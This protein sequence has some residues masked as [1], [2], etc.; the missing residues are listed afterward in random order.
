MR[1][2]GYFLITAG[3]LVGAYFAVRTPEGLELGPFLLGL[4]IGAVGIVL[5][6]WDLRKAATH[7]GRLTSDLSTLEASLER[8]VENVRVLDRDKASI[9]V[10]DLRHRIDE[11]FPGD[12]AR[13]VE[14][15]QSLAHRYGLQAYADVMN[16]FSAG[17]RYLNR[18]WST[19]TDGYIDEAHE[20]L[21][22]SHEQ[23]EDALAVV[24]R[25]RSEDG[26][27]MDGR[28]PREPGEPADS[29][30]PAGLETPE[31]V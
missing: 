15:R 2:L 1:A 3:F 14:A 22:R 16:P 19:S 27:A 20:Y 10:Y 21:G 9:D 30:R 4:A 18:V 24:W 12:L 7:A 6:R 26:A 23:F 11:R 31:N 29:L 17:E 25:L 28:L 13:F 5:V 8:I